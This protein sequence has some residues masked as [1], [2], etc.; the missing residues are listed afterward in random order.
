MRR[1]LSEHAAGGWRVRSLA[2]DF[3]LLDRWRF[4][5]ELA[6][7]VP[8]ERFLDCLGEVMRELVEGPGAAGALFRLRARLGRWLGWDAEDAPRDVP[9][10]G[11]S[12]LRAR[13][14]P[15]E[16]GDPGAGADLAARAGLVPVY[17]R[18]DEVLLEISNAT[19]HALLHLGRVSRAGDGSLPRAGDPWVPQMA[20]YVKTRGR[21]GPLYMAAIAPFRHHVVYPAMLRAVARAWPGFAEREGLPIPVS[22]AD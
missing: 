4:P 18:D 8:L 15:E 17:R 1:P 19:V 14:A 20:V 12:S 10:S 2:A 11:E 16:R 7:E 13:L 21:I 3:A 5:V 6:P 9:G 22:P